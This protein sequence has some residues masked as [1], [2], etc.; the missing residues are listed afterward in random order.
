MTYFHL[1]IKAVS[2]TFTVLCFVFFIFVGIFPVTAEQAL[3]ADRTIAE[4][5]PVV[6]G[7]LDRLLA[8]GIEAFVNGHF[9]QAV[10]LFQAAVK[11]YEATGAIHDQVSA[12]SRIG[13]SL[14]ALGQYGQAQDFYMKA[15]NLTSA[16]NDPLQQSVIMGNLSQLSCLTGDLSE[17]KDGL[18]TALGMIDHQDNPTEAALLLN[19]YGN[20]FSRLNEYEAAITKYDASLGLAKKAGRNDIIAKTLI[21][22]ARSL[23]ALAAFSRSATAL[24]LALKTC[25][26]LADNHDK[27]YNLIA[28]ARLQKQLLQER[29][30]AQVDTPSIFI[31]Q[32]FDVY[33][34][35][36]SIA[37]TIDDPLSVSYACGYIGELYEEN[38]QFT[39]GLHYTR[40]AAFSAQK[41][42]A[43]AILYKWQ[44]QAGRILGKLNQ[45]DAAIMSY[46]QSLLQLNSI[47]GDIASS[48]SQ[49]GKIISFREE[50]GPIYFEFADIL[51]QKSAAQPDSHS[52]ETYLILARNTIEQLKTVEMQDYFQ[53][54]CVT[55]LQSKITSLDQIAGQTAVIYPII[56]ADRLELLVTL[57][58]GIRQFSVAVDQKSL[59]NQVR[60]FRKK[61]ETPASRFRRSALKLYDWVIRPLEAELEDQNINTLI[62][63]PDGALRTIPMSAL[64]DGEQFLIEKYAIA[65]TPGLNLT[66]P[67][68]LARKKPNLL[69]S[70]LT[71]GVQG[72]SPL[73]NVD[74]ELE[75]VAKIFSSTIFKNQQFSEANL[76][77]ALT[78]TP[79]SIVH[80]A[81]HGQFDS[82]PKKTFILTYNGKLSMDKLENLMGLSKFRDQPVELLTLSACQTAVGDDRAALGLAG[83]AVKAGARSAL[84]SLWFINDAAT[85]ILVADFYKQLQTTSLS[86]AQALQAAQVNLQKK[87]QYSHPAYWAPFLLIGNWL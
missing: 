35:A 73:P 87:E 21:N 45:V 24:D 78:V 53:D 83:V 60:R 57:P 5:N 8:Q 54:E 80:I 2:K 65:T 50:V 36:L 77:D 66:D 26:S 33:T 19:N 71:D 32:I 44:R 76:Q 31:R 15:L 68:P 82:D 56:L 48:C 55:A 41:V 10:A 64:F 16:N 49:G 81:S 84:A 85:S 75:A 28:I 4:I 63:V 25:V 22:K 37:E 1:P 62:F 39:E 69:V 11:G 13:D 70:G 27:A 58:T 18:D 14:Q 67:R 51:L 52:A 29:T 86:K 38:N 6:D 30:E 47:R 7:D 42:D 23:A 9:S 46:R 79:Y 20:V 12:L 43:V 72:F 59:I 61:I 74:L 34:Q 3:G 40:K 17:A